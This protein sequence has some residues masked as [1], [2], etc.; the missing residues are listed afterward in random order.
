MVDPAL[1]VRPRPA[2][3][4]RRR[5]QGAR[6]RRAGARLQADR[7]RHQRRAGGHDRRRVRLLRDLH[8]SAVRDR[9]AGRHLA[10]ADGVSRRP[11]NAVGPRA[12]ARS[13]SSRR[14]SGWRT[15]S[16]PAGCTSCFYAA[17]FLVV[18]LLL[19]RGIIPSV[20]DLIKRMAARRAVGPSDTAST[21]VT[22]T[23]WPES[24]RREPARG[25]E[26]LAS[27]SA[28]S[29]RWTAARCPCELG[30]ITGLIG[31]NGSGKTTV[32][33]LITGLHRQGRRRRALQ[34]RSRSPDSDPNRIYGL[35]IGRTFQLARIFPRLTALENMLVPV[36]RSGL[37]ALFSRGQWHDE[38]TRAMDMLD[39]HGHRPRRRTARRLALVRSAQAA[40]ARRGDDGRAAAGAARRACRRRQPGAHRAHRRA[41]S[42]SSTGRESRSSSSSTTCRFV[43][44][45]CSED[46]RAAPWCRA[47]A[48]ARPTRCAAIPQC[49]TR[50]WGPR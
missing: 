9:S 26:P 20:G 23:P 2:R 3:D 8:L 17:V 18:I 14:S 15:T 13:S 43:M 36:R 41:H 49:S 38:R 50:T 42:R 28:V 32:F 6:G 25:A 16:A 33:N 22:R 47:G 35:G 39:V 34:R 5:G 24:S 10:G 45:L 7:V 46:R 11:R 4:S 29:P 30:S 37:R 27:V 21:R 40:R 44:G 12:R 48:R 19:P 1:E 31:P